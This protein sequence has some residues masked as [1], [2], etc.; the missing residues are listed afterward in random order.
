MPGGWPTAPRAA[1]SKR[2]RR[3]GGLRF[4]GPEIA[5]LL[6]CRLDGVGHPDPDRDGPA[7]PAWPGAGRALR[8]R[9]TGRADPHRR[10]EARPHR[11]GA[12]HRVTRQPRAP[13]R[14]ITDA[15]ALSHNASAGTS[16][17]S[18]S[19]TPP[20]WPTPKCST[21]RKPRPSSRSCAA[22]SPSTARH[23]VTVER[24]MTDNGSRLSLRRPRARLPRTRHPTPPHPA[25]PATNQRQGRA[26]HPHHAQ[27]LGLRRDLPPSS[28]ERTAALDGW[29]YHLQPSPT[30]LSHRPPT[31]HHPPEQPARDLHLGLVL[32]RDVPG[33]VGCGGR[34]PAAGAARRR[35]PCAPRGAPRSALRG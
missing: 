13:R 30:T 35:P 2:S 34:G 12:G 9:A 10:Q 32:L 25:L 8:A 7:G 31:A 24:V 18:R 20:G 15:Q 4:T 11:G 19:M 22:R 27:R 28:R 6:G 33:R 21:T 14:L 17:T 16:S 23:G 26:L 29:L 3:C 5:E 1:R